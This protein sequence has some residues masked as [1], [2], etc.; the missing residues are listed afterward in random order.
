VI[1]SATEVDATQVGK[2]LAQ[3]PQSG[4][5]VDAGAEIKLTVAVG[6]ETV[7]VPDLTGK[8]EAE[9]FQLLITAGLTPG[10]RTDVF[11]PLVPAGQVVRQNPAPGVVVNKGT[12]VNYDLSKGAEPTPSPTPTPT[13]TPPPTPPPTPTP[14][15]PPTLLPVGDYVC[16]D[17]GSAKEQIASDG[18]NAVVIPN[19]APDGW[20]VS[21]QTPEAGTKQPEGSPVTISAQET[22][23]G[24][25][26][27]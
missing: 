13:P 4:A 27:P 17:V 2:V 7:G 15:P 11:D 14:T 12:A 16:M 9:V 25:C 8:T 3:D 21:G 10:T 6:L 18:F 22:K 20:F 19:A 5:V 26:P 24:S 1:Q 23:P